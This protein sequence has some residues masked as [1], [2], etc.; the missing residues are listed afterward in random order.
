[1]RQFN[2]RR[3]VIYLHARDPRYQATDDGLDTVVGTTRLGTPLTVSSRHK[4]HAWDTTR[5]GNRAS[6][7][8]NR[9][10]TSHLLAKNARRG[11]RESNPHG[12]LGRLR[13]LRHQ[14]PRSAVRPAHRV[15]LLTVVDRC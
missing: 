9:R 8:H 6:N 11:R 13:P 12:Q 3:P 14:R 4:K 1:M 2:P 5:D 15:P 10:K 7:A